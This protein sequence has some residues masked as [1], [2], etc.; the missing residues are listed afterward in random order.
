MLFLFSLQF[1]VGNRA[2]VRSSSHR[3]FC[4]HN[5]V[6]FLNCFVYRPIACYIIISVC[7]K[8]DGDR[9]IIGH[10]VLAIFDLVL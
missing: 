4:F 2:V 1:S 5:F 7:C 8:H 3:P 10:L 6:F 9:L